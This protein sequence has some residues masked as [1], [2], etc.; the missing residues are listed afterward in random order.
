[1]SLAEGSRRRRRR[2]GFE[3][4]NVFIGELYWLVCFVLPILYSASIYLGK[5]QLTAMTLEWC[6]YKLTMVA[7]DLIGSRNYPFDTRISSEHNSLEK[8][9]KWFTDQQIIP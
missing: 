6:L 9:L 1:M 8:T 7:G 4:R 2:V 5:Q 3:S